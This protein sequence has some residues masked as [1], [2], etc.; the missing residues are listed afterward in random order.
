MIR[1]I[2]LLGSVALL[3]VLGCVEA[4]A[5]PAPPLT[6]QERAEIGVRMAMAVV[7]QPAPPA[8]EPGPAPR[9]R[10][11][12]VCPECEGRGKVP[13]D[14]SVFTVCLPCKG[15]GRVQAEQV[16][17]MGKPKTRTVYRKVCD[18]KTGVC[19]LVPEQ[20]PIP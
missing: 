7:D 5:P 11:G 15:T 1:S 2:H 6:A 20:E 16:G 8:P 10:P 4:K 3:L 12:D 13:R 18:P 9:P 19:T 14:G 17:S